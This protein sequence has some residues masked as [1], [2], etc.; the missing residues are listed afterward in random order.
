MYGNI[1]LGDWVSISPILTILIRHVI[2]CLLYIFVVKN[3][4]VVCNF[5]SV[6]IKNTREYTIS[7]ARAY[8]CIR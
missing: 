5:A 7:D 6:R 2:I 4:F 8:N 1:I 3:I